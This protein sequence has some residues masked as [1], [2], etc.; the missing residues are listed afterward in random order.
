MNFAPGWLKEIDQGRTGRTTK[1]THLERIHT[2]AGMEKQL[3]GLNH[4]FTEGVGFVVLVPPQDKM[5][6]LQLKLI[7]EGAFGLLQIQKSRTRS[8]S[9]KRT[10]CR[11]E[12]KSA[13]IQPKASFMPFWT[14]R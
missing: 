8:S 14:Q 11:T 6:F 1:N 13:E 5:R 3:L 12:L 2:N 9:V 4:L 7:T 10:Q